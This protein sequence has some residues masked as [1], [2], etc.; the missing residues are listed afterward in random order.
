MYTERNT[1]ELPDRLLAEASLYEECY[2][3]RVLSQSRDIYDVI[4]GKGT[5]HATLSGNMRHG[6]RWASDL[7]AVGDYVLL[8]RQ[9]GEGGHAV[10]Q[11]L[12]SRRSVFIRKAPGTAQAEQVV[13][14]NIDTV[15]IAMALNQ[16][17]NLRRLERYLAVA[18]DSGATPVVLLTKSDLAKDLAE[19]LV[20]VES[21]SPGV[22]I[23]V[24]SAMETEGHAALLP[25]MQPGRTVAFLGSSGVGKSTLINRLAGAELQTTRGL[26][27]D[28]KGR[29]TTTRRE[30][31]PLEN[32]A[33]VLDT[34]GMR[35]L[36]LERADVSRGFADVEAL[37]VECKF[38]D[39]QHDREPG[40]AV[41]AAVAAG[42]L[43]PERL[44]S[45]R[46][47]K[48]EVNYEG[49]TA[50]ALEHR[51][52]DEMFAEV[53]GMKNARKFAKDTKKRKGNL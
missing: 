34:P 37:A 35:E 28:D 12:L 47:L 24:S 46:K 13:A 50:R 3:A 33:W 9:T 44:A 29:H 22:D 49:L 42:Q 5:L 6:A 17:F 36:G 18:W 19:K 38:R 26:R 2:P 41:Q 23:L 4:T 7:P 10:I 16:D 27:D 8:D 40:C 30:L 53:G 43:S 14:A 31:I 11:H 51:K 39:C 45:Y 15:F 21:V 1:W 20:E 48:R 25:Y 32:G 52:I